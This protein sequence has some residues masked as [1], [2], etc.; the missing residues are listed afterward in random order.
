MSD[1]NMRVVAVTEDATCINWNQDHLYGWV[2]LSTPRNV[3]LFVGGFSRVCANRQ[4]RR[5]SNMLTNDHMQ[6]G[7]LKESWDGY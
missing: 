7:H 6:Q 1:R 5:R 3:Q 4:I 2:M